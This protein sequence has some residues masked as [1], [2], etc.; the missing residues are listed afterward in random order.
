MTDDHLDII[1]LLDAN[2]LMYRWSWYIEA[3]KK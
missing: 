1:A 2:K 3:E